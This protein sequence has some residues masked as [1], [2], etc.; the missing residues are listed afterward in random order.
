MY[1]IDET[2]AKNP[3]RVPDNY[4]E[5]LNRRIISA[6]ADKEAE[7]SKP[8][9]YSRLRPFLSL[10]AAIAVIAVLSYFAV[11]FFSPVTDQY[12]LNGISMQEFSDSY[13]N[14]IDIFTLEQSAGALL[15]SEEVPG[16]SQAEI[17]DY[18]LLENIEINEIYELL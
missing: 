7:P 2:P 15:F 8:P 3:F 9:L 10:A 16:V 12:P 11:R 1:K 14:D 4:F 18:L 13:L 17:I 5:D 6:T